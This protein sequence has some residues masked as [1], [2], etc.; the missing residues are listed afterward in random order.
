MKGRVRLLA[1]PLT[2]GAQV[3]LIVVDVNNRKLA[4]DAILQ[5]DEEFPVD[6]F[7]ANAGVS[8][9]SCASADDQEAAFFEVFETNTV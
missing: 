5:F 9:G 6:V 1:S 4:K 7:I 2:I 8:M 3:R